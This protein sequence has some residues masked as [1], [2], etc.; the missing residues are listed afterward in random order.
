MF[1]DVTV[2][3]NATQSGISLRLILVPYRSRSD[4]VAKEIWRSRMRAQVST[5]GQL[6]LPENRKAGGFATRFARPPT[7][8]YPLPE[9]W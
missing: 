8:C 3:H 1:Y 6:R 5:S 7:G 9:N 4:R 2:L